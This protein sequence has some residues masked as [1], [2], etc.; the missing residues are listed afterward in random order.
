M[1]YLLDL[2][3]IASQKCTIW[4]L[5]KV[6]CLARFGNQSI[7]AWVMLTIEDQ[8]IANKNINIE[9]EV[10]PFSNDILDHS[11]IPLFKNST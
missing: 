6:C 4:F 11:L 9:V 10:I 1:V 2:F 8:F 5:S 3:S 7:G